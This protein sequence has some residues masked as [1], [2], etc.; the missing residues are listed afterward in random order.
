MFRKTINKTLE[1]SSIKKTVIMG[2]V[3]VIV[4]WAI[5]LS[6]IVNTIVDFQ[7]SEKYSREKE[8]IVESLSTILKSVFESDDYSQ[9]DRL[10]SSALVFENVASI[11]VYD[12]N[13]E[14]IQTA[15]TTSGESGIESEKHD[16]FS[17]NSFQG[18][19]EIGFSSESLNQFTRV[20]NLI[21]IVS[22]VA[23]LS[24]AGVALYL[25]LNR[26]LIRP[27]NYM[28]STIQRIGP[29]SLS[30][31]LQLETNDEI[32]VLAKSFNKMADDLEHKQLAL[33][34][35]KDELEIKVEERTKGERRRADQ[36]RSI[37]DIGRKISSILDLQELF[38]YVVSSIKQTFDFYSVS[39]YTFENN[40]P[41]IK[42]TTLSAKSEKPV[43]ISL[44][45]DTD[46]IGEAYV[47]GKPQNS[48]DTKSELAVPII[49][50]DETLGVIDI[51]S[52][53]SNAFD[54]ID[55]FTVSTLSDQLGIAMENAR[56]YQEI[57]SIAVIEERNR[58]A[59]EIHD[60]LAQGFTGVILQLEAA[61][62]TL[63]SDL[64]SSQKHLSKARDLA[65]ES[66][67]EARRSVKALRPKK[68]EEQTLSE[69]V[70]ESIKTFDRDAG[71]KTQAFITGNF[72]TI[73]SSIEDA[74][75]RTTQEAFANIRKHAAADTVKYN[76][77]V[78]GK[79]VKLSIIDNGRGFDIGESK[80]GRFG[81]IGIK[82][83]IQS[84]GGIF[85]VN[86]MEGKG[87]VLNI[88]IPLDGGSE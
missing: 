25:F 61:E 51:Q 43:G 47:T 5:S 11:Q 64:E 80:P 66:L 40:S 30:T 63:N 2:I 78:S 52:E 8:A 81:L 21:L 1:F 49:I 50:G 35:A 85:T 74:L 24:L 10:L 58:M 55:V 83:R 76:L 88:V 31:R 6:L 86:S 22:L 23:F 48:S 39:I 44:P 67:S 15:T 7:L 41:V 3:I 77:D 69:A 57:K 4:L 68:L 79:T 62:Q 20:T 34:R 32:G 59:R 46:I 45:F 28:T 36:L 73:P 17:D 56:L 18:S 70:L 65:R 27:I 75:L 37:N 82:E 60:V 13:N 19:F 72:R 42:A 26:M 12:E 16:I 29:G 87:T 54:E 38:P 53:E 84:L 14:L 9:L 33:E 71:V